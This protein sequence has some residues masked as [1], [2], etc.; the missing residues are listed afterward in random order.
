MWENNTR[1]QIIPLRSFEEDGIEKRNV[2]SVIRMPL[3][4]SD[5]FFF[6]R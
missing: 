1:N 3:E 4:E 5:A 6:L 2:S